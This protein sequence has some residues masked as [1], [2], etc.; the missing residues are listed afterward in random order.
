MIWA[1]LLMPAFSDPG[2]N[3]PRTSTADST[4]NQKEVQTDDPSLRQVSRGTRNSLPRTKQRY[5]LT[6]PPANRKR[7]ARSRFGV[8]PDE[9]WM[10]KRKSKVDERAIRNGEPGRHQVK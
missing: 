2:Y 6:V 4:T 8:A 10:E 3:P 7:S 9:D 1:D 5:I